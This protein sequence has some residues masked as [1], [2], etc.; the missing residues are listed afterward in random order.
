MADDTILPIT[1]LERLLAD[2]GATYRFPPTP[3]IV[4]AVERR[5]GTG[6]REQ[7]WDS[8][9]PV[10]LDGTADMGASNRP[11]V[12][13]SGALDT[14]RKQSRI[15]QFAGLAAGIFAFAAIAGL[16]TLL[17]RGFDESGSNGDAGALP[18]ATT[19]IQTTATQP[20][21]D[22]HLIGDS[23]LFTVSTVYGERDGG[24]VE[25]SGRVTALNPE[26]GTEVYSIDTGSSP[27]AAISADGSLLVVASISSSGVGDDLVAADAA[28]GREIWRATVEARVHWILGLGPSTLAVSADGSRIYVYG[29]D[30]SGDYDNVNLIP[31]WVQVIDART[32][33]TIE[34]I[35][36]PNC[37]AQLHP[38]P[39]GRTLYVICLNRGAS[40]SIAIDLAT[41]EPVA[42]VPLKSAT[43]AAHSAV[44]SS[45]GQF[46]YILADSALA[47]IDMNE[48]SIV[49][50][51]P[52][53]FDHPPARHLRLL[54]L[55][56]D[57]ERLFVGLSAECDGVGQPGR[58]CEIAVVNSND[59]QESG[60]ITVRPPI[61]AQALAGSLDI[62]SVFAARNDFL[63]DSS[64]S[65]QGTILRLGLGEEPTV[66]A[67]KPDEEI[68]R[69]FSHSV[70]ESTT[71]AQSA[72]RD[73]GVPFSPLRVTT[74]TSG[75]E[76]VM[77]PLD[78][79]TMEPLTGYDPISLGH[80]YTHAFSPDGRT[81]AV[82]IWPVETGGAG[83][84]GKLYL[85]DLTDWTMTDTGV[86]IEQNT[87][88]LLYSQDG[89]A[90]YWTLPTTTHPAHGMT[91]DYDLYRLDLD[92][93]LQ[94]TVA[95]FTSSFSPSELRIFRAG[96]RLAIWG[97]SVDPN[98]I[99]DGPPH[100]IIVDLKADEIVADIEIP[101]VKAWQHQEIDG[102]T[103]SYRIYQPG[104]AWDLERELLYIAHADEDRITA[105]DLR[106][107]VVKIQSDISRPRSLLDRFVDWVAPS[108]AAKSTPWTSKQ[109]VL[110]PD[111]SR[112]YVAGRYEEF[113]ENEDG[114]IVRTD[115]TDLVIVDTERIEEIDRVDLG[116]IV[117]MQ[118]APDGQHLLVRSYDSVAR[119]TGHRLTKLDMATGEVI[120]QLEL[121]DLR[122]DGFTVT[123]SQAVLRVTDGTGEYFHADEVHI[124]LETFSVLDQRELENAW[125]HTILTPE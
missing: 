88:T 64:I 2:Y 35:D 62:D 50:E 108:A 109:A 69:I 23:Y 63:P 71:E 33:E 6:L 112:L 55:S 14:P 61:N 77:R 25:V 34:R 19:A 95:S 74:T 32:G 91:R 89:R 16:L 65:E 21:G 87:G 51:E 42:N 49:A 110:S 40:Q 58:S 98:N 11:A 82:I 46:L 45:D 94:E 96:T 48:R 75:Q 10:E 105:V 116:T 12:I 47:V 37:S 54:A 73:A 113:T 123:D 124:D 20:A 13:P 70:V 92:T 102:G 122:S 118:T 27:D 30:T 38:S 7:H 1:D 86:E 115:A 90:L 67:I 43:T 9:T 93:G 97:Q 106:E 120:D 103:V 79:E 57:N 121:P 117:G 56:T 26:T 81:M 3:D 78:P 68:L 60:R 59:W 36:A 66:L 104:L 39:D 83:W 125:Y 53:M 119:T 85:I 15:R 84:G 80:H 44:S 4:P 29:G 101:N 72:E 31:Y 24:S 28:T 114:E 111:G 100:V 17:F 107:G 8:S 41:S 22:L 99:V 18:S 5:L 52:L 76:L